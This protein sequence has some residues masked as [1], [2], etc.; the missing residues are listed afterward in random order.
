MSEV[1]LI[2][3]LQADYEPAVYPGHNSSGLIVYGKNVL[4]RMDECATATAGGVMLTEDLRDKMTEG[5]ETGCIFLLGPEAFRLFD[6]GQR[7]SGAIPKVGERVY[8]E[9]YAGLLARGKDGHV[10]RIM[11]YRAI[12]GGL[13]PEVWDAGAETTQ[14]AAS[15][16]A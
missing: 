6:D 5:A 9:K 14:E 15:E 11:D 8:V 4:V 13:D 16:A 7:W 3:G 1:K 2:K 12:A 10:Y